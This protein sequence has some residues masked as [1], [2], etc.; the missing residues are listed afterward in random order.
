MQLWFI[1]IYR[2]LHTEKII[3]GVV[4]VAVM[5]AEHTLIQRLNSQLIVARRLCVD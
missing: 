5:I 3:C 4:V 1:R 2:L